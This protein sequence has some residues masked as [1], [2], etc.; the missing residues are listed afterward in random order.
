MQKL[1]CYKTMPQ[2]NAQTLPIIFQEKHNTQVGTTWA[3]L[4]VL[5]GQLTFALLHQDGSVIEAHQFTEKNQL[6]FFKLQIGHRIVSASAEIECQLALYCTAEDYYTKKY[7]LKATHSEVVAALEQVAPGK[8]L[9]LGCGGGRNALY[10]NLRGFDV[11][12]YDKNMN[13]ISS[14][15]DII[16]RETLSGIRTS[17]Y[18]INKA[19]LDEQYDFIICTVVLMFLEQKRIPFIV[20]NMQECTANGRYN[21]IVAAMSKK[22]FPCPPLFSFTFQHNELREYYSGW[23]ILKY[24]EDIGELYKTDEKGNRIKLRFA[25]LLARKR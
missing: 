24:N 13:I 20:H 16:S 10:M 18:D 8:A 2:W 14:L 19:T 5:K 6:P 22:D 3:K 12:A 9:D 15:Q 4:T 23:D 11:T 25:T 21:L 17:L 7:G 1:I